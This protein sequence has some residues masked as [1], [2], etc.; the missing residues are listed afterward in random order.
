MPDEIERAE[1]VEVE[2]PTGS[3]TSLPATIEPRSTTLFHTDDPVEIVQQ[4]TR[5]ANALA[6]VLR[7]RNLTKKIG[8]RE[9]VYV[10]GW[11]LCG[12][13]LGVFPVVVWT[14]KLDDGW[15]ARAEART[16]TG[17]IVG[18]AE[19]ECLRSESK[20]SSSDDYAIRSMAQTRAV[21]KALRHPLG[22]VV[23]LA[24]F[25]PTPE[26][27]MPDGDHDRAP[28]GPSMPSV[29]GFPPGPDLGDRIGGALQHVDP[30]VDW[31]TNWEEA[32]VLLYGAVRKNL[33]EQQKSESLWRLAQ[34]AST[35][36]KN[37]DFPPPT[38]AQISEAFASAF[39]GMVLTEIA[40][41]VPDV[42]EEAP[43]K[44]G[45]LPEMD[46]TIGFGDSDAV[47]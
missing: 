11:T 5:V 10:E 21:S 34:V 36:G 6:A 45:D 30:E 23:S 29:P 38:D 33:T 46:E 24:G 22:F 43:L 26:E 39:S 40:R 9:H 25:D 15:E 32:N 4:A 41:H 27:E 1:I 37:G 12:T 19:A 16:L 47:Q 8:K 20:W 7:D 44:Q 42:E 31:R 18:A 35:L 14:R 3:S 2:D 17:A 28:R 13:M